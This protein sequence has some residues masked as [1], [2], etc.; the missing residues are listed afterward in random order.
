[1]KTGLA[2]LGGYMV[3]KPHCWW[4]S[5]LGALNLSWVWTQAGLESKTE[6]ESFSQGEI[7][8]GMD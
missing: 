1:M 7:L 5:C 8:E 2:A 6:G 4:D 3:W